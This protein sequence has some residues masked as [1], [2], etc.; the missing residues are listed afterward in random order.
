MF[1][2]FLRRRTT[3]NS[4]IATDCSKLK[5]E[6]LAFTMKTITKTYSFQ[7]HLQFT[8]IGFAFD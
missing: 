1:V 4:N 6:V 3:N 7:K 2:I 8:V 5:T